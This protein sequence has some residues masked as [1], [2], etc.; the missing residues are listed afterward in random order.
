MIKNLKEKI[1]KHFQEVLEIKTSPSSIAIGFSI[2]V[3]F[4]IFPSFGIE[5]LVMF[6]IILIFKKVSKVAMLAGYILFNPLITFPIHIVSYAI[7]NYLLSNSPVVIMRFQILGDIITYTRR[8]ILGSF[9]TATFIST[10]SYFIVYYLTKKY[11]EK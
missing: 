3:F 11:Q 7:G 4:G 9:I 10:I 8:F 6:L 1:K 5:Y 2:G